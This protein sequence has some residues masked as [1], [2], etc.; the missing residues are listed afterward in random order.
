MSLMG[1]V[2]VEAKLVNPIIGEGVKVTALVGTGAAF[3]VVSWWV[4]EKLN[5]KIVGRKRV[6]TFKGYLGLDESFAIIELE[7]EQGVTLSSRLQRVK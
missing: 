4:Y 1:H 2:C 5:L 7:G 3:T 6:E